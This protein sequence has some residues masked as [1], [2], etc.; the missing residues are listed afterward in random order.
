MTVAIAFFATYAIDGIYL[1]IATLYHIS[2]NL[3]FKWY[4]ADLKSVLQAA[5]LQGLVLHA[6]AT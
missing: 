4:F 1:Y 6:L 2:E 3:V 5:D